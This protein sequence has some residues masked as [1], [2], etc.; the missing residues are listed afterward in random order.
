MLVAAT[1]SNRDQQSAELRRGPHARAVSV[2]HWQATVAG[3]PHQGTSGARG[4]ASSLVPG[5]RAVSQLV[6][7][8]PGHLRRPP[9][10]QPAASRLHLRSCSPQHD[11]VRSFRHSPFPRRARCCDSVT[12]YQRGSKASVLSYLSILLT[13]PP[14]SSSLYLICISSVSPYYITRLSAG[15]APSHSRSLPSAFLA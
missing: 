4:G 1:V 2:R 5:T 9:S 8:D 10:P 6:A 13:L 7:V 3:R 12:C 11:T 15:R 14:P